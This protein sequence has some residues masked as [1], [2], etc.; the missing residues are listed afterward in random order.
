MSIIENES[1]FVGPAAAS[2]GLS[3][4]FTETAGGT[5]PTYLVLT[6]LDRN[7]YTAGSSNATGSFTGNGHTLG[8]SGIGS[9]ARG[10]GIIFTL[11]SNGR[12]YSSLYGYLDQ[13]SYNSSSSAGDVTNLSLFGTSNLNQANACASNPYSMM[14]A[15]AA[16]YL[17]SATVVTQ[18]K[19][20]GTVP[21][22]ATPNS[23]VA[24]ADSFVGQ[25][26]N[27]NG[28]WVLAS[29]IAADAG[30]SLPAQSTLI[31]QP[32][33]ANGE[34]IVAF[35]GP[36]GQSGNWQSTV[37][38]GEIVVI[39]TA[40]GGGHI[41]TCVSGSGSAAMLVDN[42]TYVSSA[43]QIQNS[44]H[45]GSTND[46][47][48]AAPHAASQEWAGVAASSV[49]IYE[50]DT[51]VVSANVISDSLGFKG[52]QTLST[53]FTATDPGNKAITSWQVYDTATSDMLVLSGIGYQDHSA[54]AALTATSLSAVSLL[55]GST[56]TT[57]ALDVR[58]Y[59]GSYWG[60]WTSL[61]VAI[62]A[63]AQGLPLP[64]TLTSQTTTQT[65]LGGQ[66]VSL[67]LPAN[68]FSD[69]QGQ[70]LTYSATLANG[71]ALPSWLTFNAAADRFNGTPPAV[72]QTFS[73]AVKATDT[74][75]LSVTDT[76]S[77]TVL[78]APLLLVATANQTWTASKAISLV[79]PANTFS[80]PQGQKLTYKATLSGGQAL[81]SWL[82]FSAT[83]ET[84]TGTAPSTPQNLGIT[85]TAT[86]SSGLSSSE[87][88]LAGVQVPT[89]VV[90]AGIGVTA[91]TPNQS[92]TDGQAA[93]LVLPSSTFTDA[94]GLKMT[95]AAY[96]VSGAN[97]ASWLH[98]NAT[99]E[100]LYGTV[101]AGASGTVQIA[102]IATD[103]RL[104]EA[105]DLFSV[106]F[107]PA[108]PGHLA[109]AVQVSSLGANTSFSL[110]Q[111]AGLISF[112]I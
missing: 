15:D 11:Q 80:D 110:A 2:I 86:D 33:Q 65:W 94:L 106:T 69:P 42:I 84:F 12:Y 54:A 14:Q 34:W 72:A 37:T 30:A 35:N 100:D 44:A 60:D 36:A 25:A 107:A 8:L 95:F 93:N 50:L 103:A 74:S 45:D 102:M 56:A 89:P 109:P 105:T 79:L 63:S 88:F 108:S 59:N 4:M 57:D 90:T 27:T 13:L 29:T 43:G 101:P 16:G 66:A 3:Q 18:P 19:F 22:Q 49:V 17:G 83:T 97:V 20:T 31:G 26:W 7:E 81:P 51:P 47:A 55:A 5:N 23:I 73:I 62:L 112:H 87:N 78:G 9:D 39:G 82:T 92:W 71:Q 24:M 6:A 46:V 76:F 58:A 99:T 28:C 38:A 75:G 70:K 77:A 48:V 96:D 10:A 32:G 52:T 111:T 21:A 53:L 104:A 61:S 67:V 85:V 41:T 40:G 1:A 91:Q 98:F 64:P 68:A